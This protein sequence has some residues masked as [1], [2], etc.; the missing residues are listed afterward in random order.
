MFSSEDNLWIIG[1]SDGCQCRYVHRIAVADIV[2]SAKKRVDWVSLAPTLHWKSAILSSYGSFPVVLGG[3]NKE[4][5]PSDA[6]CYYDHDTFTWKDSLVAS[7]PM[8][9]AFP[10]VSLIGKNAVMA[11]GGCSD[12]K[13]GMSED[14]SVTNVEIGVLERYNIA[15]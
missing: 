7:L 10:A 12:S 3:E 1:C 2:S 8:P 14:Y 4:N 11:I 6:V 15:N 13:Q 5:A 9:R